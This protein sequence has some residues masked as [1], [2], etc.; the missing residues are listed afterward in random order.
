[1]RRLSVSIAMVVVLSLGLT[2]PGGQAYT[3]P[4]L[5][6]VTLTDKHNNTADSNSDITWGP[7]PD[8]QP[9]MAGRTSSVV[10]KE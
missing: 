6:P 2:P 1:M 7:L 3:D 9:Y 10:K 5:D 4:V 8:G